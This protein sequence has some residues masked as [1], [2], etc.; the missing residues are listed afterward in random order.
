[1]S[2]TEIVKTVPT[3]LVASGISGWSKDQ[4]ELCKRMYCKGASDDEMK[5]FFY[6]CKRTGLD[7]FMHQI[8]AI[9]RWSSSENRNIMSIQTGIDGFR[10]ASQRTGRYRG[11]TA[12]QWCGLDGVWKEVWLDDVPPAVAKVGVLMDG[13]TEPVWGVAYWKEL[14]QKNKK[15]EVTQF[16]LK[17]PASQLA[18]CAEAQAHR[19]ASP[20]ELGGIYLAE[21]TQGMTTPEEE[22]VTSGNEIIEEF[23]TDLPVETKELLREKGYTTLAKAKQVAKEAKCDHD[24]LLKLLKGEPIDVVAEVQTDLLGGKK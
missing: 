11:T 21:E 2:E 8:Y 5:L 1:M 12:P 20:Q 23:L 3:D 6:V 9:S 16:W 17:M 19:K 15:G 22:S 14:V 4:T 24:A 18:K 10:L 13:F 7:P